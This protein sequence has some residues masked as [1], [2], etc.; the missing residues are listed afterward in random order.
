MNEVLGIEKSSNSSA[1][2]L[3]GI[4]FYSSVSYIV[5]LVLNVLMSSFFG[6]S[7][8]TNYISDLGSKNVIPFP[9][10]H[11]LICV[12]G[13]VVSLPVNFFVRNKLRVVYK[14]S[15]H[16]IL[17]VEFGVILGV[18]GNIGYIFLGI[19]S[20][21]RA[22]PGDI[23]H[24]LVTLISFGGYILSIFF[25]SLNIVLSHK[26]KLKQLGF[27][28]LIAPISLFFAYCA[29]AIPLIEWFL[30]SSILL[31]LL[32]LDYYVLKIER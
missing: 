18:V 8:I 31:F 26:C 22:G 16:S 13:G 10:M 21:D 28:G 15:K 25:F 5:L 7:I 14:S 19:F 3:E 12:F 30:L 23:Y 11:D 29:L 20:L 17:F 4:F 2:R 1:K 32:L 24:G 6:Y 27:F 9:Y